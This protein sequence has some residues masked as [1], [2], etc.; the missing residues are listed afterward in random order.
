MKGLAAGAIGSVGV[1]GY[2]EQSAYALRVE[3]KT[4]RLPSWDADDYRVAMLA[5]VHVNFPRAAERAQ[6]AVDLA[7]D[8]RPDLLVMVG[9]F[10]NSGAPE[11][12]RNVLTA[13]ERIHTA[14]CPCLA[15]LGNHDYWVWDPSEVMRTVTEAGFT[16]LRN[17]AWDH[18]GVTVAGM[19][20]ALMERAEWDF[21]DE[22]AFS[23]SLIGLMHEPD[24][25]T[26]MP[27][28][29]SLQLSG[30]SHGGQMCLPLGVPV[31]LPRG[32]RDYPQGFFP[33]APVPLYVTRGVGTTGLDFR[34]FCPPE[35]SILTLQGA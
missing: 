21:I 33:D 1:S 5:D 24:F 2:A 19:D 15:V 7:L 13:F 20:D 10:V 18:D 6:K 34:S 12:L 22:G 14:S 27:K 35:V 9:D 8:E 28:K 4:L 16:L 26:Q 25:V 23:K 29:V 11:T 32:G 17:E 30:H 3:R 31:H